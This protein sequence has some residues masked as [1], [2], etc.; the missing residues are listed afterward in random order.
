MIVLSDNKSWVVVFDGFSSTMELLN[1]NVA[2]LGKG[3][4]FSIGEGVRSCLARL[5]VGVQH[6][7]HKQIMDVCSTNFGPS[8]Y[9]VG[10]CKV[11]LLSM[12][13]CKIMF[14]LSKKLFKYKSGSPIRWKAL[15]TSRHFLD[16]KLEIYGAIK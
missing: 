16:V 2:T 15:E 8:D 12:L 11:N 3:D 13:L 10:F 14:F 7:A 4:L 6:P 1:A 5:A 9:F